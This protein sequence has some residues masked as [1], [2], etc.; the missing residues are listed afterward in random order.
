[1]VG[2]AA[3]LQDS[4]GSS[5]VRHGGMGSAAPVGPAS[6]SSAGVVSAN[7]A[8][9]SPLGGGVDSNALGGEEAV[10]LAVGLDEDSPPP[11]ACQAGVSAW[12]QPVGAGGSSVLGS[13]L[14]ESSSE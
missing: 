11:R 5:R 4:V 10:S 8:G 13:P 1:M 6:G 7:G 3:V 14:P 2:S 12:P 9:A